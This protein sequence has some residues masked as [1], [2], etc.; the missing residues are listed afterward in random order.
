MFLLEGHSHILFLRLYSS[1]VSP[2]H[3]SLAFTG[4]I[5]H[6]LCKKR[7]L[8]TLVTH[9]T[10]PLD[11]CVLFYHAC[12]IRNSLGNVTAD[13]T[14]HVLTQLISTQYIYLEKEQVHDEH[15]LFASCVI[16]AMSHHLF[17]SSCVYDGDNDNLIHLRRNEITYIK[18]LT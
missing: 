4:L 15:L 7:V 12:C 18:Y 2:A 13:T 17:V 1:S 10:L 6:F 3:V 9:L 14:L 16:M 5:P 11:I 8:T